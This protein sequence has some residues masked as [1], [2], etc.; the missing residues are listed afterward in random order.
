MI[1]FNALITIT[2][3]N[4]IMMFGWPLEILTGFITCSI[5][6]IRKYAFATFE[7]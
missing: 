1:S 7:N 3:N 4:G 6:M 2:K 5:K